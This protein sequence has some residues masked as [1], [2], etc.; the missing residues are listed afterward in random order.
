VTGK[1]GRDGS[2]ET[3]YP[4]RST[5]PRKGGEGLYVLAY[6]SIL[7]PGQRGK[8]VLGRPVGFPYHSVKTYVEKNR[9]RKAVAHR[10]K[11][12]PFGG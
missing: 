10:K 11:P 8:R 3:L 5:G 12:R 2:K 7:H 9:G 4:S 1:G 6:G